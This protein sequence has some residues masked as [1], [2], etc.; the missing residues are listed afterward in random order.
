MTTE[1]RKAA[2]E[3]RIAAALALPIELTV[4]GPHSF[5]ISTEELCPELGDKVAEYFGPLA[6]TSTEHDDECGSFVF[7]EVPA[8]P[9]S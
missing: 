6:S 8:L 1:T 3:A 5:T 7:V 2:I 9:A 4:R